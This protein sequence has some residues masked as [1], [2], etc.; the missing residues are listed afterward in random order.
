MKTTYLL[1]ILS[2]TFFLGCNQMIEHDKKAHN[3]KINKRANKF[4]SNIKYIQDKRKRI[5]FALISSNWINANLSSTGI[6]MTKIPCEQ[7][8]SLLIK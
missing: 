3:K 8:E 5:C 7:V 4:S 6:G 2:C 1:I